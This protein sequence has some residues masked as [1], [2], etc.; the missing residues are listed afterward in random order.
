MLNNLFHLE[1]ALAFSD[2][3]AQHL[4]IL[5]ESCSLFLGRCR[6]L[7][8][9]CDTAQELPSVAVAFSVITTS[10]VAC[11]VYNSFEKEQS[12]LS[13]FLEVRELS[14]NVEMT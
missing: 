9:I 14:Q 5:G 11:L 13:L 3:S 1:K 8:G 4:L 6:F 12:L 7:I 10:A 2:N